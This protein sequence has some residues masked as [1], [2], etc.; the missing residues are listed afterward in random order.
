VNTFK[1]SRLKLRQ[2]SPCTSGKNLICWHLK[3]ARVGVHYSTVSLWARDKVAPSE[4]LRERVCKA[5]DGRYSEDWLFPR[6][7]AEPEAVAV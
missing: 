4:A 2:K 6:V 5:F 3:A 7:V 1:K